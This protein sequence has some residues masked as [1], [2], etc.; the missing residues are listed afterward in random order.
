MK[1]SVELVV[2]G[3]GRTRLDR[4]LMTRLQGESRTSIQRLILGGHVRIGGRHLKPS[5][6]LH[7]GDRILVEFPD[8]IP[9]RL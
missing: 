4:Y 6:F 7:P 1:R 8:A 5:A 9:S 3:E 2:E